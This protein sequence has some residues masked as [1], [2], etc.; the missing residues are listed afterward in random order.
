MPSQPSL[1]DK[2]NDCSSNDSLNTQAQISH[3]S[4]SAHIIPLSDARLIYF[5]GWLLQP[6]ILSSIQTSSSVALHSVQELYLLLKQQVAWEQTVIRMYG[7]MVRIPRL[8]AWYA[9][10]QCGYTYSG[11]YFEPLPWLPVLQSI[12]LAIESQIRTT[13][14]NTLSNTCATSETDDHAP[15]LNSPLFN[16]AL[17]NCYRDGQDSVAWHSDDEPE[18][19]NNP[20][21][22]SLSMGAE[23]VFQLR[24]KHHKGEAY[25][26]TLPLADGDLLLMHGATQHHWQHQIP[27]TRRSVG[28]RIN[29]TYRHIRYPQAKR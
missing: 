2:P 14:T 6:S 18:L 21:V 12:R 7:K 4:P 29:I 17:V 15:L 24:H 5:P 10:P 27:K 1:F 22:A 11:K 19:G 20:I 9:D 26:Y 23:R 16:S 13:V 3:A 25:R 28:E 8:N